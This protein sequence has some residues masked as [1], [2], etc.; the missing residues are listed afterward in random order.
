MNTHNN[1]P[2]A[3]ELYAE[4]IENLRSRILEFPAITADN[5]GKARDL[6]GLAKKLA[7]D[8]DETRA[9]EKK[10]HLDAGRAIDATY[11]PLADKAKAVPAPLEKALLAHINEQKRIAQE[12]AEAAA[13]AAAAEA[14]R[15][16]EL[17]DDAILGQDAV[18]EA[19]MARQ[20]A[21][22]AA[23]SV[24]TVA[25]VKGS[26]GFRAAGVRK[27]YKVK[28]TDFAALVK[29]Y[30]NHPDMKTLAEKLANADARHHKGAVTIP[31]AEIVEVESLV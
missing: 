9:T 23:A 16:R 4:E 28:V 19:D 17:E 25:T 12:A 15:A 18:S 8:I 24:K 3:A 21:E 6:I 5:A 29:H 22:V 26:E 14:A 2:S 30:A 20:R 7:K 10:P 31:G 27:A 11:N 1:P 13:K